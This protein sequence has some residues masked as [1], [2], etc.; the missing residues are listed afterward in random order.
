MKA[1]R[2]HH[3]ERLKKKR[4]SYWGRDLTKEPKYLSMVVSTPKV[5]STCLC[6]MNQRKVEGLTIQERKAIDSY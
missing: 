3:I 4:Q 6:C 2:R 5:G 1:Q